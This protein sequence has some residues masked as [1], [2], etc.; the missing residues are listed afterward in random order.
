MLTTII[1]VIIVLG[2][3]I[4]FHELGHFTVARMFGMGV[5]TFSL[6]FGPKLLKSKHG[7]TE[8]ALS[9]I[10]LGGYVALVGETDENDIPEGFTDEECFSKRPAW[11]RLLVVLAGPVAN[12]LMAW[13][14]FCGLAFFWGTPMLT[15]DVGEVQKDSP[16]ERAG[17]RVGDRIVSINDKVLERWEDLSDAIAQSNGQ[18]MQFEIVRQEQGSK[19]LETLHLEV[20]AERKTRKTIFG[21]EE[22]AWLVGIKASSNVKK[23][24]ENLNQAFISGF[25][26]TWDMI[27]LTCKG[28]LKLIERVIPIDQVG[29]PIMIAKLVGEQAQQG[30]AGLIALTALISINLGILNLLPI[31][32]LD[33]GAIIF[34]FL[35]MII[36]KPVNRK[37]QEY[38]MRVG[39]T[40]LVALMILATYNDVMRL[41]KS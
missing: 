33:G 20:T 2:G 32:V 11:Q 15:T 9:L 40:L 4:F 34:C 25:K 1:A 17:I 7:K 22:V 28:F 38:A 18:A 37:F 41:F 12:L 24:P 16:A 8:Y 19:D 36:R 39:L 3:L 14:L 5:S 21:E 26:Q 6:G 30:L 29:G 35:E 27:A 31:P 10:P 13:I 23:R